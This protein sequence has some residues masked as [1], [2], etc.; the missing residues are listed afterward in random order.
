MGEDKKRQGV[1]VLAHQLLSAIGK[2]QPAQFRMFKI[3]EEE[4]ASRAA[5]GSQFWLVVFPCITV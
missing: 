2:K 1:L 4:V 5:C 3:S